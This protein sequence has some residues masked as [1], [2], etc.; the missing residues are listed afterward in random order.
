MRHLPV[1]TPFV[2]M[3]AVGL[4]ACQPKDEAGSE[5]AAGVPR[6]STVAMSVPGS[7]AKALTVETGRYALQ[8]ETAEW[9]TT[10]RAVTGVVNG[11]AL[12]VGAMVRIVTDYPAT[13][14]TADTAVWG[15]WQGPLDPVE[16]KVTVT[17]TAPH[18]YAYQFEGRN[19]H[20]QTAAFVTV[21]AGTHTPGLDAKGSEMEGFGSG[22]F[23]L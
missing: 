13:T 3:L 10:T 9:Y 11:A 1:C 2:A 20:D 19:K 18:H 4:V 22:T 15:P 23:S 7:N 12:A 14:V 16:W 5:Y 8:G 17:R 6:S 21:L